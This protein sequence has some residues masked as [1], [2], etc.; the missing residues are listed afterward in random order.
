[1]TKRSEYSSRLYTKKK[2]NYDI[3]A[4]LDLHTHEIELGI[5]EKGM[6]VNGIV[7]DLNP[8]ELEVFSKMIADIVKEIKKEVG[9][10]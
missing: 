9:E 5:F 6:V 7:L 8:E 3:S 2:E 4:T 1:M 10:K